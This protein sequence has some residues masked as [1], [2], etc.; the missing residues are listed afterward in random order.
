MSAG[1]Q[2][3]L[4]FVPD[5]EVHLCVGPLISGGLNVYPAEVEAVLKGH[6]DVADVAVFGIPSEEFVESVHTVVQPMGE[7]IDL[8]ELATYARTRL[9]GFKVPRTWEIRHDLPRNEAGKMR[10]GKLRKAFWG[11][12]TPSSLRYCW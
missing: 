2:T 1:I 12:S 7:T 11:D 9:A 10:K 4:G 6:P 5:A 8:D 3:S